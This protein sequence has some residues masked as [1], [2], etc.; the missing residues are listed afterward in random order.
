[1]KYRLLWLFSLGKAINR[2]GSSD[3]PVLLIILNGLRPLCLFS[4][5]YLLHVKSYPLLY[6]IL[7]LNVLLHLYLT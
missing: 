3:P 4:S 2:S 1:M 5:E 6:D 7:S